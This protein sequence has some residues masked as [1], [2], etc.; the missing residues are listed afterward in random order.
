MSTIASKLA[1]AAAKPLEAPSCDATT[2]GTHFNFAFALV[3]DFRK[4][5][6][7]NFKISAASKGNCVSSASLSTSMA[8]GLARPSTPLGKGE[9]ALSF[10]LSTS[11]SQSGA[12]NSRCG[13]VTSKSTVACDSCPSDWPSNAPNPVPSP[14]RL[15]IVF[16]RSQEPSKISAS[17]S[18]ASGDN[19]SGEPGST[20]E[21]GVG[22]G[23]GWRTSGHC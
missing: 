6:L 9:V 21:T 1:H 13:C 2:L 15:R 22:A 23:S 16:N 14:S 11:A 8:A 10:R 7:C 5:P 19:G 12:E 20:R 18:S 4:S 17:N 3:R